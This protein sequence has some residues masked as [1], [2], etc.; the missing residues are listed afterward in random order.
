MTVILGSD[1]LVPQEPASLHISPT[2]IHGQIRLDTTL[3]RID[4]Q[5]GQDRQHL[6]F[7][8]VAVTVFGCGVFIVSLNTSVQRG[9]G[10]L[11]CPGGECV[12]DRF[13]PGLPV[14]GIPDQWVDGGDHQ[15]GK[16]VCVGQRIAVFVVVSADTLVQQR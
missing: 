6:H 3:G 7:L 12:F 8:T 16:I 14:V 5:S 2:Q 1:V 9:I 11:P 10:N 4:F 15:Q 13:I